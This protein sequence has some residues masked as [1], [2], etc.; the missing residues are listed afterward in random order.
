MAPETIHGMLKRHRK[1]LGWTQQQLADALC[2][3]A[4]RATLTRQEIYRW[5]NGRRVPTFWLP[6]LVSILGITRDE[7]EHVTSSPP[8]MNEDDRDRIAHNVAAPSRVDAGTVN[9]LADA[10]AAQRRL[11]DALGSAAVLPSTMAQLETVTC[12]ARDARGPHRS[13][14][15]D[16]S[17]QWAIF[18]G[19]LATAV[20]DHAKAGLWFDRAAEWSAEAG[21]AT[22]TATVW[23]F[24]G[25][26]AGQQGNDAATVGLANAA[27]HGPNAHPAQT[28]YSAFQVARGYALLGESDNARRILDDAGH[29]ISK[30]T[31]A[32]DPPDAIY[33][34]REPFFRLHIGR[35]HLLLNDFADAADHLAAGLNGLPDEMRNAEWTG[36]Y[37]G[38]LESAKTAM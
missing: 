11:D 36:K 26:L 9:A 5:E 32:G 38:A 10:L 8:T 2:Q 20:E 25:Y 35:T 21:N 13:A 15:M 34:N 1:S 4:G 23:S 31:K 30:T 27:R 18:G 29:L 22:L 14:L 16:A 19:W 33:W 28:T 7:L 6:H 12:L 3:E 24:K 37:W 17:A